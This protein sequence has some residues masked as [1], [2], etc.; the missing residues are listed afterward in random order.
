[1]ASEVTAGLYHLSEVGYGVNAYVW[2][3]HPA[4]RGE[5][6]PILFDCGYPWSGQGLVAGLRALG[7][8]PEELCTIAITHDDIDH[9]GR[10]AQLQAVS[11]A[12][13]VAH[14]LEAPRLASD[15]WR[16]PPGNSGPINWIGAIASQIYRRCPHHPVRVTHALEDGEQLPGGWIAVHTPGHTPGHTAYYHPGQR[17]LIAGDAL[18]LWGG[19]RL[20]APVPVYTE[21]IAVATQSVRKLAALNPDIICFGH[22]RV[23]CNAAGVLCEFAESLDRAGVEQ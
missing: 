21:D 19:G 18:G 12:M 3:P 22:R 17:V 10:L 1:V 8:P 13:I 9:A 15:D 23:L 7:C 6:E 14:S 16:R 4:Q 2:H 11:G 5:G 20:R